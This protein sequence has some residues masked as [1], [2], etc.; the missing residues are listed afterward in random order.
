VADLEEARAARRK[1][2]MDW[3]IRADLPERVGT[4]VLK[5]LDRQEGRTYF[6]YAYVDELTGWE[7]RILFEE[8]TMDYM[9]KF[10]C[11][12]FTLTEIELIHNDFDG[13][14]EDVKNILPRAIDK[15]FNHREKVSALVAGHGF[16]TWDYSRVLPESIGEYK[17]LVE[18][19]RPLLGLNG[20]Y[21]I[22]VYEWK[23]KERGILFFYNM[24]RD[25]YYGE[26]R[27]KGIPG[28]VHQY[29]A[30]TTAELEKKIQEHLKKDMETLGSVPL[31]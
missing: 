6:A 8:E 10:Y 18:P 2:F 23:E 22:C 24:Y 7:A 5:K 9:V 26:L 15:R 28:I 31:D 13:F 27:D 17:R 1:Q 29:D 30:K 11:R 3:D 4:F 20:S 12:L 16:M 21:I 19:H 14:R 25:E